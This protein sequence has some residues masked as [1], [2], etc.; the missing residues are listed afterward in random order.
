MNEKGYGLGSVV[1]QE[2]CSSISYIFQ[3]FKKKKKACE[4]DGLSYILKCH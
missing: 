1:D 4:R 3:I 2:R